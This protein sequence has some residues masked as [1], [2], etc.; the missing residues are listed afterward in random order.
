MKKYKIYIYIV[1]SLIVLMIATF[2]ILKYNQKVFVG[3][4]IKSS[5]SYLL[6]IKKMNKS[7]FHIMYLK[8]GD[9]IKINF[10]TEKGSLNLL[11]TD[12]NGE[13]IYE[14]NGKVSN[15]FSIKILNDGNYTFLVEAKW[16][17]GYV[18]ISK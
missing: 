12:Q 11:I 14:G 9:L 1:I 6:D 5:D 17:K 10:A 3:E 4:K 8:N 16:A 15:E 7:D 2:V 13:T 18:H